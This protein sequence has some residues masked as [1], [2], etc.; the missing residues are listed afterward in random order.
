MT[1]IGV[2]INDSRGF[3][4]RLYAGTLRI[5]ERRNNELYA[6]LEGLIRAYLDEYDF[7][8]LETDNVG[9]YWEWHGLAAGGALPEHK[10][11]DAD[12]NE[13]AIY[14]A[15]HGVTNFDRTVVITNLFERI[16][17]IWCKDM[18]LGL[19]GEQ[20]LGA[21]ENEAFAGAAN[22]VVVNDVAEGEEAQFDENLA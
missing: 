16:F 6:M 4:R 18:G 20:F 1:G 5:Q 21:H 3:I 8:E 14:L 11:T 12:S 15:H 22:G 2:V 10:P 7:V 19:V 13:L 9:A 17:E